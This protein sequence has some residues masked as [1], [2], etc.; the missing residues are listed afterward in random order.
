[1]KA[2]DL[3]FE[4]FFGADTDDEFSFLKMSCVEQ[5]NEGTLFATVYLQNE[6][7]RMKIFSYDR[8]I[9]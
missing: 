3:R 2:L 8:F 9:G 7:F 5:N 6:L 4:E 1:M